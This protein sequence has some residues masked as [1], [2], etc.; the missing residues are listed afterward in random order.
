MGG[1]LATAVDPFD[2]LA[3]AVG[4]PSA[5]L[6]A[7]QRLRVKTAVAAITPPSTGDA[8]EQLAALLDR[9]PAGAARSEAARQAARRPLAAL[10]RAFVATF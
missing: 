9:A 3:E 6:S 10:R 2:A 8:S 4:G 5:A 1:Q 7:A